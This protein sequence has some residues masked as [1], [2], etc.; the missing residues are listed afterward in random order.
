MTRQEEAAALAEEVHREWELLAIPD[1]QR[2]WDTLIGNNDLFEDETVAKAIAG[3]R[4][5]E[6]PLQE[7]LALETWLSRLPPEDASYYLSTHLRALLGQLQMEERPFYL[8]A[9][10]LFGYLT[11]PEYRSAVKPHLSESRWS[12]VIRTIRLALKSEGLDRFTAQ[13]LQELVSGS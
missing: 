6:V 7:D 1:R 3:R 2:V 8:A 11:S 9:V 13:Q 10:D 5:D 12:L 4:F